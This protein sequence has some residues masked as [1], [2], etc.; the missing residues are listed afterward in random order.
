MSNVINVNFGYKE[1]G[2]DR[3][4]GGL[5]RLADDI[6]RGEVTQDDVRMGDIR[7]TFTIL[8]DEHGQ[9]CIQSFGGTMD[10]WARITSVIARATHICA[11]TNSKN[12][13]REIAR[14][15]ARRNREL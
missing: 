5:R 9:F 10:S 7:A 3:L 2:R 1:V 12:L 8:V 11:T 14:E 13:L 6:E 15:Q 4:P